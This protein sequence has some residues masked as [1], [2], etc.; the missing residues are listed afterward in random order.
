MEIIEKFGE[1]L[2]KQFCLGSSGP[3]AAGQSVAFRVLFIV[4]PSGQEGGDSFRHAWFFEGAGNARFAGEIK[5]QFDIS[6][7]CL[8]HE[9]GTS[10]RNLDPT[11]KITVSENA[12]VDILQTGANFQAA[13]TDGRVKVTGES[14]GVML[15]CILSGLVPG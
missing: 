2:I 6:V 7:S 10:T 15:W 13:F 3:G 12:L 8:T 11:A 1:R 9:G 5:D 14:G 4:T